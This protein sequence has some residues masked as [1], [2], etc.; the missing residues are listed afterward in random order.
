MPLN[1]K[2]FSALAPLSLLALGA[3]A[4]P[5]KADVA[6]F[7]QLPQPAGQTFFVQSGDQ[8]MQGGL[9]F[10]TY[11]QLVAQ[12]LNQQGYRQ[13][14]SRANAEL[15]VELDYG[16]DG[17]RE[18]IVSRPEPFWGGGWG[19]WGGWGYG[20]GGWGGWGRP[21]AYGWN[22]P[23]WGPGWGSAWGGGT[24]ID[25]YTYYT[26]FLDMRISRRADGQRLFEGHAKARSQNDRL[27]ELVPNLIDAMFTEFP[28]RSGEEIRI[29]IAPPGRD[30]EA[31][32][33]RV[34][35]P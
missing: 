23:F 12:R 26:S 34:T 6:R 33:P 13:A 25:S 19:G 8:G 5:F 32:P 2:L 29:T 1:K 15:V 4:T 11:A 10:Q 14:D 17:G 30:G 22:D 28:G 3:C 35:R 21:W 9:E 18:K 24:R 7:Q 20:R 31:P 16:V 27:T